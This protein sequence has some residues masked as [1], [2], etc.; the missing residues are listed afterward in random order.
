MRASLLY[1]LSVLNQYKYIHKF[2]HISLEII[3]FK[4]KIFLHNF[5]IFLPNLFL[6]NWLSSDLDNGM[7]VLFLI[8]LNLFF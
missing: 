1:T 8:A 6:I 5:Y 7:L 2:K 3:K 4:N